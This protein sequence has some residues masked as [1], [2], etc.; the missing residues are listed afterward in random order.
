[1]KLSWSQKEYKLL[2]RETQRNQNTFFSMMEMENILNLK[3]EGSI[4]KSKQGALSLRKRR[5]LILVLKDR[6]KIHNLVYGILPFSFSWKNN[7][8]SIYFGDDYV[9]KTFRFIISFML[10]FLDHY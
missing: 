6:R 3:P 7:L 8:F 5:I 10:I 1:M 4:L 9:S 2:E